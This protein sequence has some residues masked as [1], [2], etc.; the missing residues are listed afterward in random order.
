SIGFRYHMSN[1]NAAM[2]LAQLRKADR[3]I[4]RRRQICRRYDAA[5]AD[6]GL[7]T[8]PIDYAAVAPH[9][10]V[11]RVPSGKRTALIAHLTDPDIETG[12]NHI[13]NHMHTQFHTTEHS[14]VT[15]RAFQ[16]ILT[17]PLHCELTDADVER[18]IH[19]VRD[20][21]NRCEAA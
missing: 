20:G 3:F 2:G 14:P 4:A 15:E 21:L 9:I 1:I 5:F 19:E 10:Y 7:R 16:E 17:L 6:C 11:V 8:L 13:P 12:I 18:V